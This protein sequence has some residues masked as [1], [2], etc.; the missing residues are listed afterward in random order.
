M[1]LPPDV[2]VPAVTPTD[3]WYAIE[4]IADNNNDGVCCVV[5]GTSLN[6]ELYVQNEGE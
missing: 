3:S 5:A 1:S 2:N 6:G 4:A